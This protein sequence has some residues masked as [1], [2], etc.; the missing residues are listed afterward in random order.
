MNS[1]KS[2]R[3]NCVQHIWRCG[4]HSSHF[5]SLTW[6]LDDVAQ[7]PGVPIAEI[8]GYL[9][10]E[11]NFRASLKQRVRDAYR[12]LITGRVHS[13][14][15]VVVDVETADEIISALSDFRNACQAEVLKHA[16]KPTTPDSV[17]EDGN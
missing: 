10:L 5:V 12:M 4:C 3:G 7:Y 17:P 11:G 1:A 16:G 2:N 6:W 14:T 15:E 9:A 13:S 8:N